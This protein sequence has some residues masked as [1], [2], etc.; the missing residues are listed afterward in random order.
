MRIPEAP[1]ELND[2]S[3]Q[4]I[5]HYINN[6]DV[7]AATKKYNNRYLYW[8]EFKHKTIP[9]FVT[10]EQ[11]WLLLKLSRGLGSEQLKISDIPG[12]QLSYYLTSDIQ[13]KLHNFDLNLGGTLE[14]QNI[15]GKDHQQQYLMNSIMEEAIASSQLEGASTTRQ[16]A[17]KMLMQERNPKDKSEQMIFN[18]YKTIKKLSSMKNEKMTIESILDI[19]SCMTENTLDDPDHIGVF[20]KSDNIYVIDN[21]TGEI[22]HTPL[23][24]IHISQ[25]MQDICDFI[26]KESDDDFIHP[27]IKAS[28]LHFLIG[29]IHPFVD[30]NGRTARALFYWYLL[31]K[32]YWLIEY[33]SISRMIK[34]SPGQYSQA[35]LYTELDENDVTYFINYQLKTM[36][37]AFKSLK[38][39]ISRKIEEKNKL[40]DFKKI[41][42][43][44]E[45]QSYI[46][47]WLSDDPKMTFTI[48]E[49]ENRLSVVY[50]TARTDILGLEKL[51]LL[52]RNK[53]DKK[54]IL[55]YR[56]NDFTDILRKLQ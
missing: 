26:N 47:K 45:R 12:F 41:P 16:E 11:L 43:I 55:F 20:R 52:E 5:L 51:G 44:N 28:I 14:S 42:G 22:V 49:I 30:G 35:Y 40:Y 54:K 37:K 50:Q 32:N 19:H 17:K 13:E 25:V 3:L 27:I 48:K 6:A 29:Y 9:D 10:H 31:S 7:S 39:Y 33:M 36:D 21:M 8:S 2:S 1:P 46:L 34:D 18:N 4:S 24:H 38:E 15:I 23:E 56:S 53:V